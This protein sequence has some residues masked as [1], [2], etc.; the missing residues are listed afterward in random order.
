MCAPDLRPTAPAARNGCRNLPGEGERRQIGKEARAGQRVRWSTRRQAALLAAL[1]LGASLSGTTFASATPRWLRSS[2]LSDPAH[3]AFAP[4]VA[5]DRAGEAVAVW[6]R[7]RGRQLV[8][9][10]KTRPVG[11]RWSKPTRL[12]DSA[13][14]AF[15]PEVA[16]DPAGKAVVVWDVAVREGHG[17]TEHLIEATTRP[18]GSTWSAPVPLSDPSPHVALPEVA[19]DPAG[20]AVAVWQ[21]F[22]GAH[23][24]IEAATRPAGGGWSGP[25]RLSRPSRG[26]F[27]PQIAIDAAG[28]AVAVWRRAKS[29][30]AVIEAADLPAGGGWSRPTLLSRPSWGSFE[31]QIAID[32]A[33]DAV[34]VW[35]RSSRN[36]HESVEASTRPLGGGWSRP[37]RLSPPVHG[38]LKHLSEPQVAVDPAGDAV[39]VWTRS[40][41]NHESVEA[42]T[43][44]AGGG[45][46][47]PT[48]LSHP[49]G[50]PEDAE[51]QIAIDPAGEAVA[52]WARSNGEDFRQRIEAATLPAGGGWSRPTLL[53]DPSDWDFEPQIDI[54][55]AGE[56]VAVWRSSDSSR[57]LIESATRPAGR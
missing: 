32:A 11:A 5:I 30:D 24:V 4:Q 22:D 43:R 26:S 15:A 35:T 2:R 12:S 9:E 36:Y 55:P 21:R 46:S 54:D 17:G 3:S 53:S 44:P 8:I 23:F 38:V 49:R 45:W 33:G 29:T 14:R 34:A 37:T 41:L 20:K 1:I 7:S 51:P 56:A 57:W 47:R 10:A 25:T 18:T 31:P 50:R 16:M 48:R 19:I 52:V 28:E 27:E 39:A 40:S 42:A 13:E 6:E